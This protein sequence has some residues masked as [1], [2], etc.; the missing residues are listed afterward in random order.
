MLPARQ[1]IA[2]EDFLAR[3]FRSTIS[4]STCHNPSEIP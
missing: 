2:V 4:A 3:G 1:H